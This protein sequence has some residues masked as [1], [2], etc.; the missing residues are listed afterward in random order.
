MNRDAFSMHSSA[1]QGL[2]MRDNNKMAWDKAR[3]LVNDC[4]HVVL[5]IYLDCKVLE[6]LHNFFTVKAYQQQELRKVSLDIYN[7]IKLMESSA[8]EWA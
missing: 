5:G 8:W 4:A 6:N 2:C 3:F 7:K 1:K